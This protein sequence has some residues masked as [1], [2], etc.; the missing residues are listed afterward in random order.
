MEGSTSPESRWLGPNF[1]A[2]LKKLRDFLRYR[3]LS[4]E[5]AEDKAQEALLAWWA[6]HAESPI[7]W[8]WLYE[9][10]LNKAKDQWK[11]QHNSQGELRVVSIDALK[12]FDCPSPSFESKLTA[13][14][15]WSAVL[16]L[17]TP[18]QRVIGQMKV[19]EI[20]QEE[21]ARYLGLSESTIK[22]E[23]GRVRE[24]ARSLGAHKRTET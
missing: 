20:E 19:L 24:I 9:V 11:S 3:G 2:R 6:K 16:A 23:W 17:A 5:D 14:E 8:S 4:A 12:G 21:I 10:A 7:E 22:Q 13:A 1:S 18:R 15:H